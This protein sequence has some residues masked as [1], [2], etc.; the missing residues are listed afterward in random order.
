MHPASNQA[1]DDNENSSNDEGPDD[2]AESGSGAGSDAEDASGDDAGRNDQQHQSSSE[3]DTGSVRHFSAPLKKKRIFGDRREFKEH[4]RWHR[5]DASD[6]DIYGLLR[7]ELQELNKQA[8]VH[9][10]RRHTDRKQGD[11]YGDWILRRQWTTN[12]G[13]ILNTIVQCP[14]VKRCGCPCQ[15]KI[16]QTATQI[17]MSIADIHTAQNHVE[18]KAKFLTHQQRSLVATAVKLAP[19]NSASQLLMRVQDSPTKK[20]DAALKN[21]VQRMIRQERSKITNVILEGVEVTTELSSLKKLSD[22]LWFSTAVK[23]HKAAVKAGQRACVD[24]FKV[25]CIGRVFVAEQ[26]GVTLV[27][28]NIYNLLNLFRSIGSGYNV[29]LQGDVTHKASSAA[30]N[31]LVYGTNHLGGHFAPLVHALIPAESESFISYASVWQAFDVA[32]RIVARLPT[33]AS[34]DCKTCSTIA[35]TLANPKVSAVPLF[36]LYVRVHVQLTEWRPSCRCAS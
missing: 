21:S 4:M 31:K 24:C 12:K 23:E 18:D 7:Y 26:R 30:L 29:T 20:I 16:V 6:A 22:A 33:C 28:A 1:G 34:P 32:A 35:Q 10:V 15:V 14:L 8:G 3:D 11:L 27:F 13:S 17:I 9:F 5:S 2:G 19:M 25:Y 36:E